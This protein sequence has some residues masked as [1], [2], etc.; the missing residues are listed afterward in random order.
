[1][2]VAEFE[3]RVAGAVPADVLVELDGVR[4]ITE[5]VETVLHGPVADQAALVGIINHLQ[6]L[7]IEVRAVRQMAP[8]A[9]VPG[10][11]T[12]A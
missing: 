10:A 2:T 9:S 5:S 11:P 8:A 7:G 4:V 6:G 3:I 12:Q 1:M